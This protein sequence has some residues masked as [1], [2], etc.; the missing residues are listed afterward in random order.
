MAKDRSIISPSR[1]M[2]Y[3]KCPRKYEYGE[4]SF[5]HP[6]TDMTARLFGKAVH[7]A[8]ELYYGS[9]TQNPTKAT[10]RSTIER[11]FQLAW[12]SRVTGRLRN[13]Y[14]TCRDNFMAFEFWRLSEKQTPFKPDIVEKDTY[15]QKFHAIIDWFKDGRLIDFKTNKKAELTPEYQ[16]ELWTQAEVLKFVGHKVKT[17]ELFFLK[18]NKLIKVPKANFGWLY[19]L[20]QNV[21]D[22]VSGKVFPPKRSILCHWCDYKLR[23]DYVPK[24]ARNYTQ[25]KFALWSDTEDAWNKPIIPQWITHEL[26]W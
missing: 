16:I 14:N 26:E 22:A 7:R 13:E 17:M 8:I 25:R 10:I 3:T 9:I 5:Y 12:D 4:L 23:C 19:N 20:R 1:L 2:T 15:S 24:K 11:Q 18:Q 6:L 21:L